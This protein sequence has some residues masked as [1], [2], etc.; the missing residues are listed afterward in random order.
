MRF[1]QLHR[2]SR[3]LQSRIQIAQI[4]APMLLQRLSGSDPLVD[5]A[6]MYELCDMAAQVDRTAFLDIVKAIFDISKNLGP[7][8]NMASVVRRFEDPPVF[9]T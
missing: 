8:D 4:T 9:R 3:D 6:V 1:L 5:G 2:G 7:D